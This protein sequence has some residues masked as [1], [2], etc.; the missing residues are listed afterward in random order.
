MTD[1]QLQDEIQKALVSWNHDPATDMGRM[2]VRLWTEKL[3]TVD[4]FVCLAAFALLRRESLLRFPTVGQ[5][6]KAVAEARAQ[7]R[8][9]R[10]EAPRFKSTA[11]MTAGDYRLIAED[12]AREAIAKGQRCGRGNPW[13]A[14]FEGLA[15]HYAA[16][17]NLL[18]AGKPL[19]PHP[20][21]RDLYRVFTAAS[22]PMPEAAQELP[23]LRQESDEEIRAA[24]ARRAKLR[25]AG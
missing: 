9:P 3:R 2:R 20:K 10:V 22:R 19:L 5:L 24:A 14:Y 18:E 8:P 7:A 11:E 1:E 12:L 25:A 21:F 13:V 6:E 4:Y 17:A 16:N 23:G 15:E